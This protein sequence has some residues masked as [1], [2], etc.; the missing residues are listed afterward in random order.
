MRRYAL[1]ESCEQLSPSDLEPLLAAPGCAGLVLKPTLLGGVDRA[2]ALAALARTHG[3]AVTLTSAF[4]SGVGLCHVAVCA[5]VLGGP[6]VAHGLSTYDLFTSDTLEPPFRE[7]VTADLIATCTAEDAL[8]AAARKLFHVAS[9]GAARG[10]GDARTAEPPIGAPGPAFPMP[11]ARTPSRLLRRRAATEARST[12][13]ARDIA[14]A[15]SA[16]P[17]RPTLWAPDDSATHC[18][19]CSKQFTALRRRHH[20]RGCGEIF[21]GACSTARVPLPEA[22]FDNPVR[23]CDRCALGTIG[24]V[25]TPAASRTGTD[26]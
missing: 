14:G 19:A 12:S 26:T 3:R 23:A 7:L 20:C 25:Q 1:D 17:R 15:A 4:E 18:G 9:D 2:A 24:G 10:G 5:A 6:S 22:G 16:R 13:L 8:D 21:C 11:P